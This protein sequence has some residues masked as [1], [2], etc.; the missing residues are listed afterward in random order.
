M[1]KFNYEDIFSSDLITNLQLLNTEI[2]KINKSITNVAKGKKIKTSDIL[3]SEQEVQKMNTLLDARV[4]LDDQ[5]RINNEKLT[6]QRTKLKASAEASNQTE[7]EYLKTIELQKQKLALIAKQQGKTSDG[8]NRAKV[9]LNALN[10]EYRDYNKTIQKTQ[11][12]TVDLNTLLKKKAVTI[13]D[14][15]AQNK[16]LNE[17][18]KKLNITDKTQIQTLTQINAKLDANDAKLKATS[19]SLQAQRLNIGNYKSALQG[20]NTQLS[21]FGMNLGTAALAMKA[22]QIIKESIVL[23]KNFELEMAKVKAVSGATAEQFNLLEKSAKDLGASTQ[24]T[25]SEVANLQ[26]E[27]SKLG[28]TAS[29]ILKVTEATLYL[30]QATGSDLATSAEV[31]GSTLRAFQLDAS[32]TGRVTDVMAKSF[33][34]SALDLDNFSESMKYVAPIAK[35]AGLSIE[36]TTAMLAALADSGVKGSAAGTALRQ[37][38]SQ[39]DK[40]GKTTSEALKDLAEKG[41]DLAD[42]E[43]EVGKNAKTALLILTAETDK[44]TELTGEFDNATGSA[45]EM[46][47]IMG[48]T[49]DGALKRLSSAWEGLILGMETGDEGITKVLTKLVDFVTQILTVG[50]E[51]N[52]LGEYLDTLILPWKNIIETISSVISIFGDGESAVSGLKVAFEIFNQILQAFLLPLNIITTVVRSIIQ[53]FTEGKNP[54]KNFFQT[55][56]GSIP[57]LSLFVEEAEA[58]KKASDRL[59]DI[60]KGKVSR[61]QQIQDNKVASIEAEKEAYEAL[62]ETLADY[63]KYL[64]G[65]IAIM[66]KYGIELHREQYELQLLELKNSLRD[67]FIT[68]KEFTD[69]STLLWQSYYGDLGEIS[70]KGLIYT[71]SIKNNL[72]VAGDEIKKITEL[73]KDLPGFVSVF[74]DLYKELE[75]AQKMKPADDTFIQSFI[76]LINESEALSNDSKVMILEKF[77]DV[78][79]KGDGILSKQTKLNFLEQIVDFVSDPQT[80]D[81]LI[82]F[83]NEFG[84]LYGTIIEASLAKNQAL[85]DARQENIDNLKSELDE[86]FEIVKNAREMGL[87]YDT[88]VL[89]EKKRL[90][91]EEEAAQLASAKKLANIQKAQIFA[92]LA[93][94]AGSSLGYAIQ[95]ALANKG[96]AVN[97]L[98]AVLVYGQYL[99]QIISAIATAKSQLSAIPK[100]AKGGEIDGKRHRDGG[101]LIEAEGGEYM[102]NRRAYAN[103]PI[104]SKLINSGK[105]K[106]NM[107]ITNDNT[108]VEKLLIENNR[109]TK[110]LHIKEKNHSIKIYKG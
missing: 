21:S 27:F 101:V 37:I 39:L 67:Q 91:A 18:K 79:A 24:F 63:E 4:K 74:S 69:F 108:K 5:L 15:T 7:K 26:L 86:E 22:M 32:E 83:G 3:G 65:R 19:S 14:L 104:L 102:L 56:K 47:L 81:A 84:N 55:I 44:I 20:V 85:F 13:T 30:A 99:I 42:A 103:A 35:V 93:A 92:Q 23:M 25:A 36:E 54:I 29:E 34:S 76:D 8:Y 16:Q 95:W 10:K 78:I 28:F 49:L 98:T 75:N 107:I 70:Q 97:P 51:V 73:K 53:M 33:S 72:G 6:E 71:E 96:N 45:K 82:N 9:Q 87:A 48:D 46:A 61:W 105:I 58:A 40:T 94:N 68:Q 106:D 62:L 57:I 11:T 100:F 64:S 43:D 17:A 110:E 12:E 77:F 2:D 66:Q 89:N 50:N 31:A 1:A 88:Q 41:L 109:L 60:D 59:T 90:L 52:F 80:K 38:I